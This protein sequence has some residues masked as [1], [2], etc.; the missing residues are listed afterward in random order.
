MSISSTIA[1]DLGIL[2]AAVSPGPAFVLTA[3]TSLRI[4]KSAGLRVALGVVLAASLWLNASFFGLSAFL[5]YF[6][7][8]ELALK[9]A[10]GAYLIYLGIM[11]WRHAHEPLDMTNEHNS[12]NSHFLRGWLINITNP[13]AFVFTSAIVLATVPQNTSL[14]YWTFLLGNHFMIEMSWLSL[15]VFVLS[16]RQ[17]RELYLLRKTYFDRACALMLCVLGMSIAF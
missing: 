13:K 17:A 2:A 16:T 12:N 15:C 7:Q 3:Q 9:I 5:G 1:F 4:G 6:P 14:A 11:M 10:G 8:T